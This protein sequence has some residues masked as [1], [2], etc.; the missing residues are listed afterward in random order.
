[1][2]ET[3]SVVTEAGESI[4]VESVSVD[5]VPWLLGVVIGLIVGFMVSWFLLGRRVDANLAET[6]IHWQGRVDA[7]QAE[8]A[9]ANEDNREIKELL[10]A[11][12]QEHQGCSSRIEAAERKAEEQTG[13][14]T[15]ALERAD[16]ATAECAQLRRECDSAKTALAHEKA[17]LGDLQ[18]QVSKLEEV[19]RREKATSPRQAAEDDRPSIASAAIVGAS[20]AALADIPSPSLALH[21]APAHFQMEAPRLTSPADE[22]ERDRKRRL[23]AID[24]RIAQLPAGSSARRK[25]ERER[26]AIADHDQASAALGLAGT[27]MT[28]RDAA[29][30]RTGSA[31]TLEIHSPPRSD[32]RARATT[33]DHA[34]PKEEADPDVEENAAPARAQTPKREDDL[35]RI[36][37]IGRALEAKLHQLG[38][39]SFAQIAAL[40]AAGI[41]ALDDHLDFKGRIQREGWVQQARRFVE[42]S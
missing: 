22:A 9:D 4:V 10:L 16:A 12:Q 13:R 35:K 41:A 11:L 5:I 23:K 27:N 15:A 29:G 31:T 36:K 40:D 18:V 17:R 20:S 2:V 34:P 7:A 25:L 42:N 37:G 6:Q 30:V 19:A 28:R 3:A 32:E 38:Y 39:T 24:A 8:L 33:G 1:M 21:E 14:A 26:A